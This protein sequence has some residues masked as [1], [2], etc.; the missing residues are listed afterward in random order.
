MHGLRRHDTHLV[1][2]ECREDLFHVPKA[3][4]GLPLHN[5]DVGAAEQG[6]SLL[7]KVGD[8]VA[9]HARV[10]QGAF[11]LRNPVVLQDPG[12]NQL[13]VGHP[14][15]GKVCVCEGHGQGEVK[16]SN[17]NSENHELGCSCILQLQIKI[18]IK[19]KSTCS[20]HQSICICVSMPMPCPLSVCV[21]RAGMCGDTTGK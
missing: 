17:V 10:L 8:T 3:T 18:K 6:F 2:Q 20:S 9:S 1:P 14:E 5:H 21:C 12:V 19:I 13:D 15:R 7:Q 11:L 4:R 16:Y